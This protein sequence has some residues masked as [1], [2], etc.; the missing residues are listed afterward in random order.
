MHHRGQSFAS[1]SRLRNAPPL[2]AHALWRI[3]RLTPPSLSHR[4]RHTLIALTALT[5]AA[6]GGAAVTHN[7]SFNCLAAKLL[8]VA[9]G[10]R[11]REQF[12]A[13]V[14]HHLQVRVRECVCGRQ[15]FCQHPFR[16]AAR[17]VPAHLQPPAAALTGG[18]V[19]SPSRIH[20]L[21][22]LEQHTPT[23]TTRRSNQPQVES[24]PQS[25]Q[26][27]R[28]KKKIL[29]EIASGNEGWAHS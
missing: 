16:S 15:L 12:M 1:H 7:A 28:L 22:R 3:L 20:A 19:G 17:R 29:R 23:P 27:P 8:V 13:R 14:A 4:A 9:K 6:T 21:V 11:Q 10:W 18:G 5:R 24:V 26:Q 2:A 25:Y